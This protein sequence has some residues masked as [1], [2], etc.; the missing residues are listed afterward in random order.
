MI[1]M[2]T[3]ILFLGTVPSALSQDT[4][5]AV[6]VSPGVEQTKTTTET[7]TKQAKIAQIFTT[8]IVAKYKQELAD[9][10]V[11]RKDVQKKI[12]R[13]EDP[14]AKQTEAM[15]FYRLQKNFLDRLSD[16][17]KYNNEYL[18]KIYGDLQTAAGGYA[19]AE[20][21]LDKEAAAA[22]AKE[23]AL[24]SQQKMRSEANALLA[25]KKLLTGYD[26]KATTVKEKEAK[27]DKTSPA[28]FAYKKK[29]TGLLR[30]YKGIARE[31]QR[32]ER[33]A[34]FYAQVKDVLLAHKDKAVKWLEYAGDVREDFFGLGQDI[35]FEREKIDEMIAL[36]GLSD[37]LAAMAS[38]G[39]VAGEVE[40][41]VGTLAKWGFLTGIDIPDPDDVLGPE[42][43]RAKRSVTLEEIAK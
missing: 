43:Q 38:L 31:I 22:A 17:L 25:E 30:R 6:R 11:T 32:C 20:G 41:F 19:G 13:T 21:T 39:K 16:D 27:I 37:T 36:G 14:R 18:D 34:T 23:S 35:A 5:E 24:R 1:T 3:A 29:E 28:W 4:R 2:L 42:Q 15:G 10:E 8:D 33:K 12:E 7:V 26:P 9:L 40:G